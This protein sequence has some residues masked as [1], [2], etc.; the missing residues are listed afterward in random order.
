MIPAR[1][2]KMLL[3]TTTGKSTRKSSAPVVLTC[4]RMP[5]PSMNPLS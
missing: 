1:R 2:L 5:T 4:F 3:R